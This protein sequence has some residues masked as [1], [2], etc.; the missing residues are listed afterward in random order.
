MSNKCP[1]CGK[2]KPL[3][4]IVKNDKKLAMCGDCVQFAAVSKL[5]IGKEIE[6]LA[7]IVKSDRVKD[8]GYVGT[9]PTS[10]KRFKMF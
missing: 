2:S 6:T 4:Y 5:P 3:G 8:L 1:V 7:E 10:D 9:S